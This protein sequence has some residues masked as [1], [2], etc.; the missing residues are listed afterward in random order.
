VA[1]WLLLS[2]VVLM[3]ARSAEPE[4]SPRRYIPARG[5]VAYV[6]YDGL[7]AHAAAW[8]A[9]ATHDV[10]VKTTAGAMLIDLFKQVT[11]DSLKNWTIGSLDAS[12]VIAVADRLVRKGFACG[13]YT[14]GQTDMGAMVVVKSVGKPA[15]ALALERL[16]RILTIAAQDVAGLLPDP[17]LVRGRKVYEFFEEPVEIDAKNPLYVDEPPGSTPAPPIPPV[18]SA[19][20]EGDDLI[21]VFGNC[22]GQPVPAGAKTRVDRYQD[23]TVY[24]LDTIEG[25]QP[26]VTTHP[27]F[28]S[29]I[30]EGK[31]LKG[32]E[33]NGLWFADTTGD[34][35][36]FLLMDG[37][38]FAAALIVEPAMSAL[39][40][41]G[42][43][44]KAG[45]S[46]GLP[47]K[48]EDEKT[49]AST[50]WTK[51]R[52]VAPAVASGSEK[53]AEA[54]TIKATDVGDA[55]PEEIDLLAQFRREFGLDGI[56]RIVGRW[57]FQGKA[58]LNDVRVE[59]PAPRK[60]LAG[61]F[62]QPA[63]RA[64]RLPGIPAEAT[65]FVIASFDPDVSDQKVEDLFKGIDAVVAEQLAVFERAIKE[66]SGLRLREDLLRHIG[67]TWAV[68]DVP[69]RAAGAQ[70]DARNKRKH[71]V[72]I[73]AVEDADAFVKVADS[74]ANR[75]DQALRT[76]EDGERRKAPKDKEIGTFGM[77]RLR[78]PDRGYRVDF[79]SFTF[80]DVGSP[81][82]AVDSAKGKVQS[83]F[84]L[85]G[86]TSL[87]IAS[88]LDRAREVMAAQA[89]Q[90]RYWKP[91][92]EVVN[93][94]DG[95]PR[96]LTFLSV[97]DPDL[98]AIPKWI[99]GLPDAIRYEQ[100]G[101][102]LSN[103]LQ[104]KTCWSLLN[105]MGV[106]RPGQSWL[107]CDRNR[108]PAEDALRRCVFA[109]VLAA[110]VDERGYR[111][112]HREPLPF[113]GITSEIALHQKWSIRWKGFAWPETTYS[114][115]VSSPRNSSAK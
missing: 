30:A 71:T 113:A 57:G 31:D 62:D 18:A 61:W 4:R 58:L 27:G 98:C 44:A 92:G 102:A 109:S 91:E 86:K 72:F 97:S 80:T 63:F 22:G 43:D 90:T 78:A 23:R 69:D 56:K 93:A 12:D 21:L 16:R 76:L 99:A 2:A 3:P 11:N 66:L 24:V 10:L 60:G 39:A 49:P 29:A 45:G 68:V 89:L 64:D 77:K 112:I 104:N 51:D 6:E 81:P 19:W 9:T 84:L 87:V 83:L 106:P 105:L 52:S 70:P 115:D 67:P 94:F 1:G 5:L 101:E 53:K 41:P 26:D 33:P 34:V 73:A 38:E 25:R 114:F 47:G 103:D 54:D 14:D 7:D 40:R 100:I 96:N 75:I 50:S 20:M 95:L 65:D 42:T 85:V 110:A 35:G 13:I 48:V 111:V 15:A 32:F 55:A 59:A 79:P 107:Q 17:R 37:L 88:S 46:T 28:I 108:V 8:Q 82:L 36:T 74:L